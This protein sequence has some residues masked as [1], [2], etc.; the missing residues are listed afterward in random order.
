MAGNLFKKY[1]WLLDLISSYNGISHKNI[2]RMWLAS[3]INEN[4]SLLPKRTLHNHIKAISEIFNIKIVC[5]WNGEYQCKLGHNEE[6]LTKTERLLLSSLRLTNIQLTDTDNQ[7]VITP[8][9]HVDKF[10]PRL[11][12]AI[13]TR[14]V[15]KILWG[16]NDVP[17]KPYQWVCIEPYYVKGYNTITSLN[18]FRWYLFGLVDEMI[19]VYDL[20]NIIDI[21]VLDK[22]FEHPQTPISELEDR[23]IHSSTNDND[24]GFSLAVNIP[25]GD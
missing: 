6:H 8:N 7:Y 12:E 15:V 13:A 11:Y 14:K 9:L 1:V 23:I 22:T 16:W 18:G 21:E 24:D 17:D 19:S 25:I 5:K 3:P 2:E 10:T 4:K 20:D